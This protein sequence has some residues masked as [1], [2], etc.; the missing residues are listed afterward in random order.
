MSDD[1]E[2]PSEPT[3]LQ[4]IKTDDDYRKMVKKLVVD[5]AEL[6]DKDAKNERYRRPLRWLFSKVVAG[7]GA[8][9]TLAA[10]VY[11]TGWN[12]FE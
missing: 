11:F 2:K 5:V 10:T 4:Y 6:K 7:L 8:A 9:I 12:P 3:V 1:D